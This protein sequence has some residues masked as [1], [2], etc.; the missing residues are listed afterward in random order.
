MVLIIGGAYQGKYV[1]AM[2]KFSPVTEIYSN[3]GSLEDLKQTQFILEFQRFIRDEM[4]QGKS[5]FEIIN[6]VEELL[7][8]NPDVIIGISEVGS[9]VV[10]VG[11]DARNYRESVGRI[12]TWLASRAKEVYRVVAGIGLQLK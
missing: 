8:A 4:E 3:E 6:E 9:G 1:F 2:E 11:I 10:P 12:S 5:L 7:L